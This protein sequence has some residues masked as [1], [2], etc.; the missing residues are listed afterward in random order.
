FDSGSVPQPAAAVVRPYW[1]YDNWGHPLW[2]TA[3]AVLAQDWRRAALSAQL[4]AEALV[5]R[6][7]Y[8]GSD[9]YKG[10]TLLDSWK[11]R[12]QVWECLQIALEKRSG[13]RPLPKAQAALL[14]RMSGTPGAACALLL[15]DLLDGPERAQLLAGEGLMPPMPG[16]A[17]E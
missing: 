10:T 4:R 13:M 9:P 6:D 15:L 8:G 7:S 5:A 1:Q 12:A 16:E 2:V 3:A 14:A 17:L 11:K